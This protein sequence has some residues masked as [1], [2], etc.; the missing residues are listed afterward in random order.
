MRLSELDSEEVFRRMVFNILANNTDDHNKNFSFLMNEQG[1][2]SLSPAYDMTYIFNTGG[3]LPETR[4]CLM[5][6]GKYDD[7]TYD[8]VMELAAKN[9][10]RKAESIIREVGNAIMEFRALAEQNGVKEQWISAVENT[11]KK[12]LE[13]WGLAQAKAASTYLD[14]NGRKIENARLEQQ[15][16]GNYHLLAT[17]DGKERKY[18]I[19]KKTAEH[20][21]ISR[22][23]TANLPDGYLKELVFKYLL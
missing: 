14:A 21:E 17:I 5:I 12:N 23:G 4:H 3:F 22:M 16:K 1:R 13:F 2:W 8:D 11:L 10:I 7:I 18:V 19:R 9:G 20:I 6:R 15:Y